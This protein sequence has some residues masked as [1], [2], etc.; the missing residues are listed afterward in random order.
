MAAIWLQGQCALQ[1]GESEKAIQILRRAVELSQQTPAYVALLAYVYARSGWREEAE[2]LLASL[3]SSA[4]YVSPGHLLWV[5]VGLG[6]AEQALRWLK[7]SL[8]SGVSP[9]IFYVIRDELARLQSDPRFAPLL[10]RMALGSGSG[11]SSRAI[12]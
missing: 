4:R 5:A 10:A 9:A 1:R 6:D 11:S 3:K 7:E 2:R 8:E 12:H